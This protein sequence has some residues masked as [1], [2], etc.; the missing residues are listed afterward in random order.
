MTEV[1]SILTLRRR[2]AVKARGYSET[3]WRHE[4]RWDVNVHPLRTKR[5]AVSLP[6]PDVGAPTRVPVSIVCCVTG[7]RSM[8][9]E[10]VPEAGA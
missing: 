8:F 5:A 10:M 2:W 6:L 3:H 9:A 7:F 4:H 1:W